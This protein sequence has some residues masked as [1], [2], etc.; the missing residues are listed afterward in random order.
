VFAS[1]G[2]EFKPGDILDFSN[3]EAVGSQYLGILVPLKSEAFGSTFLVKGATDDDRRQFAA[4]IAAAG[5]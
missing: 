2:R 3:A 1:R 4:E 5:F